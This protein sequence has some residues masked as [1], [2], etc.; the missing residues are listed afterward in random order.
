MSFRRRNR[1]RREGAKASIDMNSLIDLTFLLLVVFIVT[2][3]TLEQS[4]KIVLPVGKTESQKDEKKPKNYSVS[5]TREN[6]L[7]LG[8]EPVTQEILKER[9]T[10][11]VE[12][13][14]DVN[15]LIRGDVGS[16]YGDVYAIVKIAKDAN[17]KHLGLVSKESND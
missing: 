3:P 9:L 14:P 17:V 12:E 13:D 4:V 11:A 5:I 2:L 16:N 15:V 7:F 6:Q 10:K 8:E 1:K